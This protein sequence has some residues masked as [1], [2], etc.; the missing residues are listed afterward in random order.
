MIYDVF[1]AGK[2]FKKSFSTRRH[3]VL[4]IGMRKRDRKREKKKTSPPTMA[5]KYAR[6]FIGSVRCGRG[7]HICV[8]VC[9]YVRVSG[10]LRARRPPALCG[11]TCITSIIRARPQLR[12]GAMP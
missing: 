7:T 10:D 1:A 8:C 9:A 5:E 2:N 11:E 6:G 4:Y 12:I 3:V